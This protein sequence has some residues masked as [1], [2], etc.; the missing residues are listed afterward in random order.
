MTFAKLLLTISNESTCVEKKKLVRE[1][2]ILLYSLAFARVSQIPLLWCSGHL[3]GMSRVGVKEK[4]FLK[5]LQRKRWQRIF[6][7]ESH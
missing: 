1:E 7:T 6:Q 2:C 5:R 3:A 4:L